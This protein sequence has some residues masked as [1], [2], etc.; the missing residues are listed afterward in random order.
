MS[1]RSI[2][3]EARSASALNHPNICTVHDVAEHGDRSFIVMEYVDGRPLSDLIADGQPP[4]GVALDMASQVASALAHA[5]ER[6]VVHGDLK[7]ANVLARRRGVSRWSTS[8]SL[9]AT[10]RRR[11]LR[12]R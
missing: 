7:A 11:R 10:R 3:T 1:A 2:L 4:P 8:G 6:N 9:V 5:H 12:A